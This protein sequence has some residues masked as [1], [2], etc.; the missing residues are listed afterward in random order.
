MYI[1]NEIPGLS[2]EVKNLCAQ[3]RCAKIIML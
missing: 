2:S 1:Y 3:R